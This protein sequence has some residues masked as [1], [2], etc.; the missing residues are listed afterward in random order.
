MPRSVLMPP[1]GYIKPLPRRALLLFLVALLPSRQLIS[2]F[3]KVMRTLY[4]N[5]RVYPVTPRTESL[6]ALSAP[7][8]LCVIIF[9]GSRNPASFLRL[10]VL[11][12]SRALYPFRRAAPLE[13]SYGS[14]D[15]RRLFR[16]FF[17][18]LW[19]CLSRFVRLIWIRP[20]GLNSRARTAQTR[21][22]LA[23][24]QPH[25]LRKHQRLPGRHKLHF[26]YRPFPHSRRR[27][28]LRGSY[29]QRTGQL[30][31]GAQSRWQ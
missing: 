31:H 12:P 30:R 5:T 10:L 19:P 28:R 1:G 7:V 11:P 18:N 6:C 25:H 17:W 2:L 26:G 22:R 3:L 9:F 24:A 13:A 20:A 8:R 16:Q 15:T 21:R 23:P 27:P 4:K 14:P 29:R